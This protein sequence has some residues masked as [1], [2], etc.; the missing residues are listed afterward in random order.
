[1]TDENFPPFQ[2]WPFSRLLPDPQVWE[3]TGTA[4]IPVQTAAQKNCQEDCQAEHED[5]KQS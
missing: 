4:E 1:M 5:Y 3:G 2:T